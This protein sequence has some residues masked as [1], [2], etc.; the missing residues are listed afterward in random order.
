M[1]EQPR[2]SFFFRGEKKYASASPRGDT[3]FVLWLPKV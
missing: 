2:R 1:K 3:A